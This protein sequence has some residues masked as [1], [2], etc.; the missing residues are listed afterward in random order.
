MGRAAFAVVIWLLLQEFGV[1]QTM[2]EWHLDKTP[3]VHVKHVGRQRIAIGTKKTGSDSEFHMVFEIRRG[4]TNGRKTEYLATLHDFTQES[5]NLDGSE[6]EEEDPLLSLIGKDFKFAVEADTRD[7]QILDG[8]ALVKDVFGEEAEE[9]S[10]VERKFFTELITTLLRMH[11]Q[12]AFVPLPGKPA[13][14]DDTW[15]G[16]SA[17]V[18]QP[19]VRMDIDRTFRFDGERTTDGVKARAI[20]WSSRFDVQF[21]KGDPELSAAKPKRVKLV[22]PGRYDGTALWDLEGGRPLLVETLQEYEMEMT[23]EVNGQE[24][25]AVGGGRD[26]LEFRFFDKLPELP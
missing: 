24:Q 7:L 15:Q 11:L 20:T 23:I 26:A 10:V 5:T 4:K 8:E 6:D 9:L 14:V 18:V 22:E 3:F 19:V 17:I 16:K 25:T 2:L 12:D 1:A 13:A 21:L